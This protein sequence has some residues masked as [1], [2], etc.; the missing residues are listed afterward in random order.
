MTL[1]NWIGGWLRARAENPSGRRPRTVQ[2][3]LEGLEGRAV[4]D[5]GVALVGSAITIA[6]VAPVNSVVVSYTDPSHT[7]IAVTANGAVSDF[8]S[9]LVTSIQFS[10]QGNLNVFE[11]LTG[12]ASTAVGGDGIN[13]FVGESGQ[14]TFIGGN[15][16]NFFWV[17]GGADTLSG[18]NGTNIFLGVTGNDSVTVGNGNNIIVP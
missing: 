9:S 5:G 12:V 18:G 8:S 2:P 6:A 4:L 15:G 10:G 16:Y 7:T 3:R 13:F 11:N 1:R 14:D 17:A